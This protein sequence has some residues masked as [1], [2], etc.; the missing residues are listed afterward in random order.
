[1]LLSAAM[2]AMLGI[3]NVRKRLGLSLTQAAERTGMHRM[4]FARIENA[5][6][7][8]RASTLV[9][10]ARAFRVPVGDLFVDMDAPRARDDAARR[11]RR[12]RTK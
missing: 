12:K 6:H 11:R 5:E 8:P 3:K 1:M 2:L 7:D 10:I 9:T 4:T